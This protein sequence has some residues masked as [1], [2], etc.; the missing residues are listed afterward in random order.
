MQ[1]A[2]DSDDV[3]TGIANFFPFSF[4]SVGQAAKRFMQVERRYVYSTPKTYLELLKL[5][6]LLLKKKREEY[7]SAIERLSNG[8][9]KLAET[10]ES[11]TVR[12]CGCCP[13]RVQQAGQAARQAGVC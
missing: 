2:I 10:A 11:G 9:K 4:E 6:T 8:L 13:R 5:F 7:D 3:R 1:V 12:K